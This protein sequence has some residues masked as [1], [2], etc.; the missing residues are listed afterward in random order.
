NQPLFILDSLIKTDFRNHI[1]HAVDNAHL[2]F[3][4]FDPAEVPRLTAAQA[5]SDISASAGAI[6]PILSSEIVDADV[7]NLRASFMLGLCHGYDVDV[8]AIQYENGPAP[9]DYRDF[10][11]NSTFRR[12]T[13][14]HVTEF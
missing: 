10:I 13:E 3:R 14:I 1:F 4:S 12:E 8:M 5:I 6:L 7:H 9:M 11:T 2:Q